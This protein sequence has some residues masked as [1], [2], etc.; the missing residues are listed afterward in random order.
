M[1]WSPVLRGRAEVFVEPPVR[2]APG[3]GLLLAQLPGEVFAQQRMG[4]ERDERAGR[5]AVHREQLRVL[6][7]LRQKFQSAPRSCRRAARSGPGWR[8]LAAG[9]PGS[10][11]WRAGRTGRAAAASRAARRPSLVSPSAAVSNHCH[12]GIHDAEG[13]AALLLGVG[14][15]ELHEVALAD[16]AGVGVAQVS[17]R[18]GSA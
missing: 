4:V 14:F 5:V 9:P 1:G 12:V 15:L 11:R 6:Q 3:L 16:V 10:R 13:V 2:G 17:C 7:P 8:A 18:A